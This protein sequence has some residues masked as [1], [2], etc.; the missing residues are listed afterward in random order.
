MVLVP[1]TR[2]VFAEASFFCYG[3]K[4]ILHSVI[5]FIIEMSNSDDLQEKRFAWDYKYSVMTAAGMSEN[6][7]VVHHYI[8]PLIPCSLWVTLIN[9]AM[10]CYLLPLKVHS[11]VLLCNLDYRE[12][13]TSINVRASPTQRGMPSLSGDSEEQNDY[14]FCNIEMT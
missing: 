3:D 1:L 8:S 12:N 7:I 10:R 9:V 2:Y 4:D 5:S 11:Y 13:L 6:P 14:L